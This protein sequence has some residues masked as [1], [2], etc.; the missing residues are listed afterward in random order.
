MIDQNRQNFKKKTLKS[1]KLQN[2]ST[3]N[4]VSFKHYLEII[5]NKTVGP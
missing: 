3:N 5:L 4:K 1:S 2:L